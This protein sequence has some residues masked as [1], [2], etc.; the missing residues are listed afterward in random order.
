MHFL[1]LLNSGQSQKHIFDIFQ[2]ENSRIFP[3]DY[4]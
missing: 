2:M 1:E 3:R 4:T